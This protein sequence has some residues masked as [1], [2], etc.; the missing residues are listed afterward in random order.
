MTAVNMT[1]NSETP[2]AWKMSIGYISPEYQSIAY[3]DNF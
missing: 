2:Y 1:D 3:F